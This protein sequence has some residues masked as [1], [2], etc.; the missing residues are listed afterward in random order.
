MEQDEPGSVD[1]NHHVDMSVTLPPIDGSAPISRSSPKKGAS[2]LRP[3]LDVPSAPA[4]TPPTR[5]RW[6]VL[7]WMSRNRLAVTGSIV[8][9]MLCG[10]AL[11]HGPELTPSNAAFCEAQVAR[12]EAAAASPFGEA[13]QAMAKDALAITAKAEPGHPYLQYKAAIRMRL[14]KLGLIK[15]SHDFI[16]IDDVDTEH[17]PAV[18]RSAV[19]LDPLVTSISSTMSVGDVPAGFARDH[20]RPEQYLR[21]ASELEPQSSE[22]P[23]LGE[24]E[25]PTFEAL[26]QSGLH[27]YELTILAKKLRIDMMIEHRDELPAKAR[28]F[29]N[30]SWGSS[31]EVIAMQIAQQMFMAPPDSELHQLAKRV[32]GEELEAPPMGDDDAEPAPPCGEGFRAQAR[33]PIWFANE[34]VPPDYER[35]MSQV[36]TLKELLVY[37]ELNK[38]LARPDMKRIVQT[39]RNDLTATLREGRRAGILVFEAAGNEFMEAD[40]AGQ[41]EGSASTTAYAHGPIL[42]GAIDMGEPLDIRDDRVADFSSEGNIA[43]ST[44]GVNVPVWLEE[45]RIVNSSG[46][47]FA[48]PIALE[49]A[50]LV[51]AIAPKLSV[52][53]ILR[54]LSDPRVA[55]DI[56]GTTRDGAGV[57]DPFAAALVAANPKLTRAQIDR[58]WRELGDP[59]ADIYQI[60][61]SLHLPPIQPDS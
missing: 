16:H 14:E 1:D 19:G 3:T 36:A 53:G 51:G 26:L 40:A 21:L 35:L 5:A 57:V 39:A 61:E 10:A 20:L 50:A 17:G 42:V 33:M 59:N 46:T 22:G 2:R 28:I 44:P 24:G 49:D 56:P 41:P 31:P 58:A 32:L 38:A 18:L 48:S 54:V 27:E 37:P 4:P 52:E 8:G 23:D 7:S 43:F 60:R 12:V 29:T 6:P 9:A 34:A 47:S 30:M 11:I 25:M 45:G 55:L 13:A 15:A